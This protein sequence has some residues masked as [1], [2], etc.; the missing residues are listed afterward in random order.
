MASPLLKVSLSF[1]GLLLILLMLAWLTSL[2][3][4]QNNSSEQEY[5]VFGPEQEYDCGKLIVNSVLFTITLFG[6][7]SLAR[8]NA[9]G[10]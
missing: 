5:D 2:K 9:H 8:V 10:Y 1:I 3:L 6:H 4:Y 7:I